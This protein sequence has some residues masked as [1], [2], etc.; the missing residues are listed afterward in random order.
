MVIHIW[1]Y[2]YLVGTQTSH[3]QFHILKISIETSIKTSIKNNNINKTSLKKNNKILIET[4][5]KKRKKEST[6]G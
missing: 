2:M 5:I 6:D 4:S 1:D 3:S